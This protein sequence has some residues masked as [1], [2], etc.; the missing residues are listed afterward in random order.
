MKNNDDFYPVNT[1][2]KGIVIMAEM[3]LKSSKTDLSSLNDRQRDAV[4]SEDKRVLVLAGAR[5]GQDENAASKAC[6]FD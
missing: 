1:C 5:L 4:V 3:Q 2:D 6:L